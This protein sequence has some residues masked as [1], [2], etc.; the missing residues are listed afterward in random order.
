MRRGLG[1]GENRQ[2]N[3]LKVAVFRGKRRA[4][5]TPGAPGGGGRKSRGQRTLISGRVSRCH[6]CVRQPRNY[7]K[8]CGCGAEVCV[9]ACSARLSRP[10]PH[11]FASPPTAENTTNAAP[12]CARATE[13]RV[14]SAGE[15]RARSYL[16]PPAARSR[17]P[18]S[19]SSGA[20]RSSRPPRSHC[21]AEAARRGR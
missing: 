17:S 15:K 8:T 20:P 1:H 2:R 10:P 4:W 3:R 14:Q 12:K 16:W 18:R 7:V 13:S 11:A 21:G 19:P 5:W 6:R 9:R